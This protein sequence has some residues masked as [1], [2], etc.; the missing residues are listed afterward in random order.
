MYCNNF[1]I[2]SQKSNMLWMLTE[3][4]TGI[5]CKLYTA[6]IN[7]CYKVTYSNILSSNRVSANRGA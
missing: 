7:K 6:S 3:V 5:L 2:P 4:L 1:L